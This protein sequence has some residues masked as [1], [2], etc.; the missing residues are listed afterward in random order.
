[1]NLS[2][3]IIFNVTLPPPDQLKSSQVWMW[4][5]RRE[6]TQQEYFI[7]LSWYGNYVYIKK[8]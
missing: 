1:M 5:G 7:S 4:R 2:F 3:W 6:Y 8:I